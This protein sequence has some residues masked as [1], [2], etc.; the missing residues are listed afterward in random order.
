MQI[1]KYGEFYIRIIGIILPDKFF[2]GF[3]CFIQKRIGIGTG[4]DEKN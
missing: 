1:C 4:R 2:N 3:I